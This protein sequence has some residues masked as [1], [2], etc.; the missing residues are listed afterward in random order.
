M[1]L[2]PLPS[3]MRGMLRWRARLMMLDRPA[4]VCVVGRVAFA[5]EGRERIGQLIRA[6]VAAWKQRCSNTSEHMAG[7]THMVCLRCAC[8]CLHQTP[9]PLCHSNKTQPGNCLSLGLRCKETLRVPPG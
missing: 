5:G 8:C 3:I 7:P 4:R 2:S 9:L 1:K 6:V